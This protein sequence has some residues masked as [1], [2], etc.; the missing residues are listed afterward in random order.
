MD[1]LEV[2][3]VRQAYTDLAAKRIQPVQIKSLEAP[4]KAL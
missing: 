2:R 4:I 1:V 3:I